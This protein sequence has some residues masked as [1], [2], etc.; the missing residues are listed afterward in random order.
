M[1]QKWIGTSRGVN[2]LSDNGTPHNKS[3]DTWTTFTTTDGL[4]ANGVEAIAIDGTGNK[5]IA[6]FRGGV[7]VLNDGGTPHNKSDDRWITFTA[8]DGLAHNT[9]YAVVVDAMGRKWIGNRPGVSVL[10]DGGT[11]FNKGDDKWTTFTRADGLADRA[12]AIVM[13]AANQV[14]FGTPLGASRLDHGGTLQQKGDDTWTSYVIN[15]WLPSNDIQAIATEGTNLAWIGSSGG[16]V[17]FDGGQSAPFASGQPL[18]IIID[19]AGQKWLGTTDGMRVFS[20]G[21]TPF[22]QSDDTW[23]RFTSA[24]GLVYN[25]VEDIAIDSAGRK[26]LGTPRG[27]SVLED[28]GT[29]HNKAD[30]TWTSFTVADGMAGDWVHA[31]AVDGP[32]RMWFVHENDGMSLLDHRGTPHSKSDDLWTTFSPADGLAGNSVYSVVVDA[33]GRKWFG[34]CGGVSVLDDRGT[35]HNKSDDLWATFPIGDCNPGMVIDGSGRK[36]M[37]TGWSGVTVLDDRGTPFDRSDDILTS[38]T[39]R[40]GLVDNRAQAIAISPGGTVWVGTDGGLGQFKP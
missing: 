26:W 24:D 21:G 37:A 23:T 39:I 15:D 2:V 18:A 33:A 40:E 16:L 30:D 14:W 1:E 19:R 22:N 6:T 3:D 32:N 28:K 12:Q 11:P 7:S 8:A 4:A 29:P 10:E 9:T 34:A 5:W 31:V 38:Y 17:A 13:G 35:P 20:D 27:V 36:W 25:S